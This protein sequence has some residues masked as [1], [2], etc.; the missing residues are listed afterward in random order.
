[1]A[2]SKKKIGGIILAAGSASRMGETK[3]LL[4]FKGRPIL[5]HVIQ[6]AIQSKL[7]EIVVVLGHGASEIKQ[8]IDFSGIKIVMNHDFLKGQSS[9]LIKGLENI[10]PIC[11]AAM[12]LLADQ[13]LVTPS[14]INTIINEFKT[15]SLPVAIP[16]YN[17]IRGNPVIIAKS[18]FHQLNLL[19]G[20]TGPRILF[21]KFE[22]SILKVPIA[23]NAILIDV[24][25]KSDYEKL[26]SK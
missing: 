18:L 13:P 8:T 26:I 15:S 2:V 3:Q 23:S 10:S 25:T 6:N 17:D 11:N 21:K 9:S 5:D 22:K 24:D 16:Y 19:S 7:N 20:D 4:P 1:M 12:F 14:M